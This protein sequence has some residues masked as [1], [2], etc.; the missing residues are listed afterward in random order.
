MRTI[1]LSVMQRFHQ[2]RI[3]HDAVKKG[4]KHEDFHNSL[5]HSQSEVSGGG[6]TLEGGAPEDLD[7]VH[8]LDGV[9]D[10]RNA[11]NESVVS[12]DSEN[13]SLG[14]NHAASISHRIADYFNQAGKLEIPQVDPFEGT[15]DMT[16][17][18]LES[19]LAEYSKREAVLSQWAND[20]AE[21]EAEHIK[22]IQ[23][24][25]TELNNSQQQ[26]QAERL[27]TE[28]D[29]ASRKEHA[30][31][32][33]ERTLLAEEAKNQDLRSQLDREE[34]EVK[35]MRLDQQTQI[36]SNR[37]RQHQINVDKQKQKAKTLREKRNRIFYALLMALLA[38]L[39]LFILA[40][41]AYRM[42]RWSVEE[43]L[44]KEVIEEVVVE[45]EVIEEVIKEVEIEKEV[46]PPECTQI[47]RN[48]KVYVSCD[49]V[50]IDGAPTIS[51][52]G[53]DVPEL[54]G[55]P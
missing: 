7:N 53:V 6:N 33:A 31:L 5:T 36:I 52:T 10:S 25:E 38:I 50:T 27:R 55:E 41:V 32:Q 48:G 2:K 4:S 11:S 34:L 26:N 40:A 22:Q 18:E 3:H 21:I 13:K 51:E 46:I 54:L 17:E 37:E 8:Q 19:H 35:Q 30:R 44:I 15:E 12:H 1:D 47:R 29:I 28:Q 45:K 43:P 24:I 14:F 16:P 23:R 20:Q 42:W 9:V 39:L 49:G